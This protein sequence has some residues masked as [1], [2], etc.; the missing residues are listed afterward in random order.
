MR[1]TTIKFLTDASTGKIVIGNETDLAGWPV[2]G[3]VDDVRIY[4]RALTA[5]QIKA[6]FTANTHPWPRY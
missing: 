2:K 3:A 1:T 6:L 4:S 5:Q